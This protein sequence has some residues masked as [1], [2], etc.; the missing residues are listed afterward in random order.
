[1][2][3]KN[4]NVLPYVVGQ[5]Y[6]NIREASI[7]KYKHTYRLDSV[8]HPWEICLMWSLLTPKTF[9]DLLTIRTQNAGILKSWKFLRLGG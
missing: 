2:F 3:N 9:Y 5:I 4:L 7:E 6:S 8:G 1:M